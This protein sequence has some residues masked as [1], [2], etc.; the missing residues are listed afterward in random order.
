MPGNVNMKNRRRNTTLPIS[1]VKLEPLSS[2]VPL[3]LP[4]S[5]NSHHISGHEQLSINTDLH[6]PV[7]LHARRSTSEKCMSLP[8]SLSSPHQF[9]GLATISSSYTP[10]P[11]SDSY[12]TE[13][14]D[15]TYTYS[16][17]EGSGG[18]FETERPRA[19]REYEH[20]RVQGY[21]PHG[22]RGLD[23]S[24][25]RP[26][27]SAGDVSAPPPFTQYGLGRGGGEQESHGL[28]NFGGGVGDRPADLPVHSIR[29]RSI[30]SMG[31]NLAMRRA[32]SR[33][34]SGSGSSGSPE[35]VDGGTVSPS[36][37]PGPFPLFRARWTPSPHTYSA[38]LTPHLYP[39]PIS[40]HP[41]SYFADDQT[42]LSMDS[43]YGMRSHS[44]FPHSSSA[45]VRACGEQNHSR[46]QY[47]P[48]QEQGPYDAQGRFQLS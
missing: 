7:P 48:T 47:E 44:T 5:S 17:R 1:S 38:T 42:A 15:S 12:A 20:D 21:V 18:L 37:A 29:L 31:S 9:G 26:V 11:N 25:H 33:S 4:S 32:S 22:A 30:S 8:A 28:D 46:H 3:A 35:S 34:L 2:C 13:Y 6:R 41:R 27:L 23:R 39:P 36:T 16:R 19:L 43:P 24:D 40:S 45:L 10:Y 14:T